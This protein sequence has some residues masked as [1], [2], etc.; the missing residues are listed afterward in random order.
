MSHPRCDTIFRPGHREAA[1]EGGKR[2]SLESYLPSP[3]EGCEMGPGMARGRH[4]GPKDHG[5]RVS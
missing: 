2:R 3:Q 5:Q 1:S 4:K